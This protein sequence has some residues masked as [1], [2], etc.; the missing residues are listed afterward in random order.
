MIAPPS[1]PTFNHALPANIQRNQQSSHLVPSAHHP[2]PDHPSRRLPSGSSSKNGIVASGSGCVSK[3]GPKPVASG[4]GR[5]SKRGPKP[6]AARKYKSLLKA[7]LE[8]NQLAKD[9]ATTAAM[10]LSQYGLGPS[11]FADANEVKDQKPQETEPQSSLADTFME[12]DIEWDRWVNLDMCDIDSTQ[13]PFYEAT[14]PRQ[15]SVR[16]VDLKS[17]YGLFVEP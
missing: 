11:P 15:M 12:A 8:K 2:P 3:R 14:P 6:V 5:V 10:S 4:S 17:N 7:V 16:P 13:G 1:N 9:A